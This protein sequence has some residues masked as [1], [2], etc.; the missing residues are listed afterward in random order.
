MKLSEFLYHLSPMFSI[1]WLMDCFKP[2]PV[3]IVEVKYN[4]V[5]RIPK[6][7]MNPNSEM[8]DG[9]LPRHCLRCASTLEGQFCRQC[10]FRDVGYH[11]VIVKHKD[12]KA[13]A[14][15]HP[16]YD[17]LNYDVKLSRPFCPECGR[18]VILKPLALASYLYAHASTP[19]VNKDTKD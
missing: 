1:R 11:A 4:A 10:G 5:I 3:D 18:K 19:K 6:D 8:K 7:Q 16:F 9:V 14:V 12:C 17:D 13:T 2:K 15:I